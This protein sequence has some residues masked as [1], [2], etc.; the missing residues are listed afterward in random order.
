[1]EVY[2]KKI[3]SKKITLWSLTI[4]YRVSPMKYIDLVQFITKKAEE[5]KCN[6]EDIEIYFTAPEFDNCRICNEARIDIITYVDQEETDEEYEARLSKEKLVK[7]KQKKERQ[8]R[9]EQ[10]LKD[11]EQA[12]KFLEKSGFNVSK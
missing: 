11:I 12:K 9:R 3:I 6:I 4:D 7:E 5:A 2:V 10:K 8:R 1:M